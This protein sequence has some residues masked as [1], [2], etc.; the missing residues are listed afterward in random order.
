MSKEKIFLDD[1]GLSDAQIEELE[2]FGRVLSGRKMTEMIENWELWNY[3]DPERTLV[4]FAGHGSGYVRQHLSSDF[5]QKWLMVDVFAKRDWERGAEGANPYAMVGRMSDYHL[6][7]GVQSIV[8]VDDVISS[9]VTMRKLYD[10]NSPWFPGALWFGVTW[11]KQNAT[12]LKRFHNVYAAVEVGDSNFRVPI[13]SVSTLIE[14]IEVRLDYAKCN[15]SNPE[16]F[17][18]AIDRMV[19]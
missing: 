2:Q 17:L 3:F 8:V 5:F 13:N 1:V 15:F 4:V 10:M 18:Q 11:I 6:T 14:K 9:G 7:Y 12:T 19:V 16:P